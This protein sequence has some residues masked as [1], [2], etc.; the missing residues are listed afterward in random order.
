MAIGLQTTRVGLTPEPFARNRPIL[1]GDDASM[2]ARGM[3]G[4]HREDNHIYAHRVH[5]LAAA[6]PAGDA[7]PVYSTTVS[8]GYQDGAGPI[9]VN[10]GPDVAELRIVAFAEEAD[11]RIAVDGAEFG[12]NVSVTTPAVG[13]STVTLLSTGVRS[14]ILQFKST[15]GMTGKLWSWTCEEVPLVAGDFP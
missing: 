9:V 10:I 11:W 12:G 14:V 3:R 13:T 15:V 7:T 1:S 5:T 2:L 6:G 4:V 8:A